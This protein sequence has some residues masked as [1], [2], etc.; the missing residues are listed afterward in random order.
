[1]PLHVAGRAIHSSGEYTNAMIGCY[2]SATKALRALENEPKQYDKVFEKR[3][4]GAPEGEG[5]VIAYQHRATRVKI[6]PSDMI[7]LKESIE[8]LRPMAFA[9]G[10]KDREEERPAPVNGP[11]EV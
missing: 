9:E 3:R 1:M 7:L 8:S 2:G 4:A 6:T 10:V 5:K 11:I